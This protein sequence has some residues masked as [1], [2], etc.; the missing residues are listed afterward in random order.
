MNIILFDGVCNLCNNVVLLIIKYDKKNLLYFS[1]QQTLAGE[2]IM[3]QHLIVN[4]QQ[5]IIFIK[6][7]SVYYKSSAVLE[8]AKCLYGWPKL[9]LIG[10]ILPLPLRE[11]IYDLIATNR[12]NMFGKTDKCSMPSKSLEHKFIS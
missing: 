9:L 3:R 4:H 1:A 11:W 10:Y 5:T 6:N 7:E 12:Y 8:I 2:K